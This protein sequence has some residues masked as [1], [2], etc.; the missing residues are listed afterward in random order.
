MS[1]ANLH[2]LGQHSSKTI[3]VESNLLDA[4]IADRRSLEQRLRRSLIVSATILLTL[5]IAV[6]GLLVYVRS[7]VAATHSKV[8]ELQMLEQT[9]LRLEKEAQSADPAL[10]RQDM[11][12]KSK[13]KADAFISTLEAVWS[14]VPTGVVLNTFRGEML[15]GDMDISGGA[16]AVS[17]AD[18]HQMVDSLT[19]TH[20]INSALIAASKPSYALSEHGVGFDFLARGSVLP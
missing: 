5:M 3:H 4:W 18:A 13:A 8:K 10:K 1:N 2:G 16:D 14:T 9:V 17:D 11:I 12:A 7:K 20:N 15:G 19:A 6:P